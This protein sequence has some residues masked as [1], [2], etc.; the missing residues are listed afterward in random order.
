MRRGSSSVGS[1]Q[2]L[3]YVRVRKMAQVQLERGPGMESWGRS[4]LADRAILFVFLEVKR[5][6]LR[7]CGRE[8]ARERHLGGLKIRYW[9]RI[10]G[11]VIHHV[12]GNALSCDIVI[13]DMSFAEEK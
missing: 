4:C 5:E 9:C 1:F 3:F 7:R 8:L 11:A 12:G 10:H 2:S 6:L 13:G